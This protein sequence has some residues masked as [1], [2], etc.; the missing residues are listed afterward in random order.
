MIQGLYCQLNDCDIPRFL[1]YLLFVAAVMQASCGGQ[2]AGNYSLQ[3]NSAR[4][5]VFVNIFLL[6]RATLIHLSVVFIP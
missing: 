5:P 2:V 1:K 3:A 4:R 6:H